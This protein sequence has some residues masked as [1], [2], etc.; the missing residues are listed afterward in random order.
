MF[1]LGET[2]VLDKLSVNFITLV[3]RYRSRLQYRRKIM[4]DI[5]VIYGIELL[6]LQ[7]CYGRSFAQLLIS[8][9]IH[10]YSVFPFKG[11]TWGCGNSHNTGCFKKSFTTL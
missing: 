3:V 4:Q 2:E 6:V 7:S 9:S 11:T 10:L 5:Y 8:I 1:G